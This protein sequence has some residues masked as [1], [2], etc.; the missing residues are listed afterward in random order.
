MLAN[1]AFTARVHRQQ[2]FGERQMFGAKMVKQESARLSAVDDAAGVA[3]DRE[4][5]L[6]PYRARRDAWVADLNRASSVPLVAQCMFPE[7][8]WHD[9][10]LDTFLYAE[11][12]LVP[13]D[14]WNTVVAVRAGQG[15]DAGALPVEQLTL[16]PEARLR[17]QSGMNG[18]QRSYAKKTAGGQNARAGVASYLHFMAMREAVRRYGAQAAA[19]SRDAHFGDGAFVLAVADI[20]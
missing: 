18:A 14:P 16:A 5:W 4:A 12:G 17:L 3:V 20:R 7:S 10:A 6:A 2:K 19:H 9:P 8:F 13:F 11:M 1:P 15:V